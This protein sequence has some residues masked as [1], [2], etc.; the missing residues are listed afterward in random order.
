M[1]I[2]TGNA[3]LLVDGGARVRAESL[4]L[5]SSSA[6]TLSPEAN[7]LAGAVTLSSSEIAVAAP[8]TDVSGST[9]G[10]VVSD[11]VLESIQ[12]ATSSLTLQA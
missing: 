2:G 8:G 7:L 11:A 4:V 6:T 3:S 10:L 12:A 9:A 5:D 1:G